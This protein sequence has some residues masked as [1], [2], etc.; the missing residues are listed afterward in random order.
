MGGILRSWVTAYY[1]GRRTD[2]RHRVW[3]KRRDLES[4]PKEQRA[5]PTWH[6]RVFTR[7]GTHIVRS[8][9]VAQRV[10][11]WEENPSDRIPESSVSSCSGLQSCPWQ[12][13]TKRGSGFRRLT[14]LRPHTVLI[15]IG[16]EMTPTIASSQTA[17]GSLKN[18]LSRFAIEVHPHSP[19]HSGIWSPDS[20]QDMHQLGLPSGKYCCSLRFMMLENTRRGTT[21]NNR[22]KFCKAASGDK[23]DAAE[24]FGVG[25]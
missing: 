18:L 12:L 13:D 8:D 22:T 14:D 19:Y 5:Q 16:R 1:W 11:F 2:E 3:D 25:M 9:H 4:Y 20:F 15:V 17:R 10:L 7:P 23:R 6:D 21:G 24:A